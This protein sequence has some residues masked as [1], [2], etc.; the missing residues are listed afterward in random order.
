MLGPFT[1]S[2]IDNCIRL[3]DLFLMIITDILV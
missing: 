3:L 2:N 1:K